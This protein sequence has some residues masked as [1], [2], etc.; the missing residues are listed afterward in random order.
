MA[1][2]YDA[3]L[4]EPDQLSEYDAL[5]EQRS[6]GMAESALQAAAPTIRGAAPYVVGGL[7]LV[8]QVKVLAA[9]FLDN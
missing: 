9:E 8:G 5:L 3:L 6:P 4:S 2:E 7:S 1:S